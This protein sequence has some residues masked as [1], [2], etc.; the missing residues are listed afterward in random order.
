MDK[1]SLEIYYSRFGVLVR[2][3]VPQMGFDY[4]RVYYSIDAVIEDFWRNG[5]KV[6]DIM[7][8]IEPKSGSFYTFEKRN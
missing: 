4:N 1:Y 7:G 3:I 2:P 5:W 6:T 8:S